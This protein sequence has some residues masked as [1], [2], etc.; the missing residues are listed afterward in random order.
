MLML[1]LEACAGLPLLGGYSVDSGYNTQR[2][3]TIAAVRPCMWC[4]CHSA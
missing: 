3:T 1:H 2:H 4:I